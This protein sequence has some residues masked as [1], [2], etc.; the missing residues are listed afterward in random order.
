MVCTFS[1]ICEHL[2]LS[3][4]LGPLRVHGYKWGFLG[5][6]FVYNVTEGEMLIQCGVLAYNTKA[7]YDTVSMPKCFLPG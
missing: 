2:A 6:G 3:S 7:Q 4:I 5:S 1:Q